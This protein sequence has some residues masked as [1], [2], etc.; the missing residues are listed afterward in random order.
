MLWTR[1]QEEQEKTLESIR[2]QTTQARACLDHRKP[3]KADT[4]PKHRVIW[5]SHSGRKVFWTITLYHRNTNIKHSRCDKEPQKRSE[6]SWLYHSQHTT[7]T[8]AWAG[9][10]SRDGNIFSRQTKRNNVRYTAPQIANAGVEGVTSHLKRW[11]TSA[12]E[13]APIVLR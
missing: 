4:Q 12:T 2:G 1:V 11:E 8:C 10:R 6:T 7:R 9:G 5:T 13:E 3:K